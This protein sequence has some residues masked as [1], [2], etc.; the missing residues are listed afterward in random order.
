[1]QHQRAGNETVQHVQDRRQAHVTLGKDTVH[2]RG[3]ERDD[4]TTH[5]LRAGKNITGTQHAALGVKDMP[6]TSHVY[7]QKSKPQGTVPQSH[8]ADAEM[9]SVLE[10]RPTQTRKKKQAK[11]TVHDLRTNVK[12]VKVQSCRIG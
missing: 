8:G 4:R 1:M 5:R 11:R 7:P 6:L 9:P 12:L 3:R 2:M 10:R